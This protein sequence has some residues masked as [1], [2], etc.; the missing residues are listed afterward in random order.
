MNVGATV[1]EGD[2][3]GTTV[4]GQQMDSVSCTSAQMSS[5]ATRVLAKS[6]TLAQVTDWLGSGRFSSS[7]SASTPSMQ[8]RH[9]TACTEVGA[10][11][12]NDVMTDDK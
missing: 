8:K 12:G 11:V 9:G 1:P 3:V 5:P 2:T 4:P 7:L 10:F 6:E